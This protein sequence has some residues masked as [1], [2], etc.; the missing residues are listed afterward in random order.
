AKQSKVRWTKCVLSCI[1]NSKILQLKE[2]EILCL[3]L[4]WNEF[5]ILSKV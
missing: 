3:I 2:K 4:S 1:R 5:P